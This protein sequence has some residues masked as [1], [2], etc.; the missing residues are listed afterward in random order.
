[1]SLFFGKISRRH[2]LY[3]FYLYLPGLP[4]HFHAGP[5]Q[6]IKSLPVYLQRRIHGRYL[7]LL[8]LKGKNRPLD[9]LHRYLLP[10]IA[11][12][13]K[14]T[15]PDI[16]CVRSNAQCHLRHIFLAP[17]SQHIAEF[18]GISETY[19]Q[20]ALRIR[21]QGSRMPDLFLAADPSEFRHHIIGGKIFLLFYNQYSVKH[22]LPPAVLPYVPTDY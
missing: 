22:R 13:R 12:V 10:F 16:L 14:H 8:S 15:P 21:I 7:H 19:R 5:G 17:V 4:L 11:A 18:C 20:H 3:L 2:D 1:M 9:L 6:L